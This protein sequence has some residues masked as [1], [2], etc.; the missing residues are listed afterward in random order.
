MALRNLFK[1]RTKEEREAKKGKEKV[2]EIEIV[3]A[4]TPK[5][6]KV[7]G[8]GSASR[9]LK[10]PHITEKAA[11]LA[12]KNQYVFKIFKKAN[13]NEIKK[14]IEGLYGVDVLGVKIINVFKK[15]RRMGRQ[16]GYKPGYKKAIVK[17]KEGQKIEI[18][19]R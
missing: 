7:V 3:K 10:S 2:K 5:T 15:P 18:L 11:S 12:E 16:A 8:V 4:K 17:I 9:I 13:K 1:K 6:K 14:S 19:P